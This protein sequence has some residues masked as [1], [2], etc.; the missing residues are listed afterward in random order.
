MPILMKMGGVKY[1]QLMRLTFEPDSKA[2]DP[3]IG[4]YCV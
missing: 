2:H 4:A 3:S 1:S